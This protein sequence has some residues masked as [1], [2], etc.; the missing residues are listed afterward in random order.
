MSPIQHIFQGFSMVLKTYNFMFSLSPVI[1]PAIPEFH[2]HQRLISNDTFQLV[3]SLRTFGTEICSLPDIFNAS[4]SQ[5]MIICAIRSHKWYFNASV[6]HHCFQCVQIFFIIS[7]RTIFV[8]DLKHQ[9]R[10]TLCELIRHNHRN[11][12]VIITLYAV[13]IYFVIAAKPDSRFR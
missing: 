10:T 8:L 12:F 6:Y 7:I 5:H 9:Y 1:E 2:T 4:V 3:K 13:Q 11:Q